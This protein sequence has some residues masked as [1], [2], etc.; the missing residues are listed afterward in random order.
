[1]V[2]LLTETNSLKSEEIDL[3]LNMTSAKHA[4]RFLSCLEFCGEYLIVRREFC[5]KY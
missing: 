5:G 2:N 3:T 4:T 1:M